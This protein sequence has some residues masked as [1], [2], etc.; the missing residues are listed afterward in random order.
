MVA[1]DNTGSASPTT[2][3]DAKVVGDGDFLPADELNAEPAVADLPVPS[4]NN[5]SGATSGEAAASRKRWGMA[6]VRWGGTLSVGLRHNSSE[7]STASTAQVYEARLRANSYIWKPYIALVS[8]DFALTTVRTKESGDIASNNLIGTSVTGSGSLSLFPQSRFP[9][10][11][12]LAVS[13]SRSEGSFSDSNV[14]QTRLSLRQDYRPQLGQWSAAAGYDRSEL[15]GTFGSDTVDRVFGNYSNTLGKH[16]VNLSGDFSNSRTVDQSSKNY[17]LGAIHGYSFSDELSLNTN[18]SITGQQFDL[19]SQGISSTAKTQSTQIFSYANWTPMDSKWRGSANLRYFQTSNTIRGASFENRTL[20][21]AASATY[22]ASRNLNFFGTVGLNVDSNRRTN[23]NQSLGV[24]YTGDPLRLGSYDYTWF[25]SASV[26][27]A[28]SGEGSAFRSLNGSLGHSLVRSWQLS[29]QTLLNG[30][31]NQSITNSRTTGLGS[32]STTTLGHGASL[33]MQANAGDRLT[34]YL[35]ASFSDS[36]TR[37]DAA[38]NF[39]LLNV[40]L[41]G[42]WRIDGNSELDSNLTWQWS[43]QQSE[44]LNQPVVLIDEF[45]RPLFR[46]DTSRTGNT[47]LSGGVGYGHRRFLGIRGLRYRLDF[48]AN[49]NRDDSRRFGNPDALREQDR[50]TLDLDQRLFY[51]I[52]RLDTELQYRIAEIEGQRNQ[53]IFFRVIREFGSF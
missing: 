6:P 34:G 53:L 26:A 35:S 30:S 14:K 23:S 8:G 33:S 29:E 3:S 5:G 11:A 16:S 15:T 7:N 39:Q 10:N 18:A 38:S 48:R 37:G 22:Q 40:Q 49:T 50:A 27:N 17:F 51:R 31:L 9:F 21:G 12:S 20:G 46:E 2:G 41:T 36:R 24:S 28:T 42:N 13:D 4:R 1:A 44:N 52:G 32:S 25:S 47:S 19:G 43:R 45:G